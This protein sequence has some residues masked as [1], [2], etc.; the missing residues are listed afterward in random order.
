MTLKA[1]K[2]K[3]TPATSHDRP[4]FRPKLVTGMP[5]TTE[6]GR[7]RH[8]RVSN[9][10]PPR[11]EPREISVFTSER[12]ASQQDFCLISAASW[13]GT[14]QTSLQE[15]MWL[16]GNTGNFNKTHEKGFILVFATTKINP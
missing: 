2:G 14:S 16:S 10:L 1:L 11:Q 5:S 7:S 13:K 15:E 3:C 4:D 12:E 9:Q 6:T 8:Q